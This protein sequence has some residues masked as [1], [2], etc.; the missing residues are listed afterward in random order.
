MSVGGEESTGPVPP[1]SAGGPR[2]TEE[3]ME[4]LFDVPLA[5]LRRP[6]EP[7]LLDE[8]LAAARFAPSAANLQPWTFVRVS[9]PRTVSIIAEHALSSLGLP[10]PN[11]RNEALAQAAHLVLVCLNVLRAKCRFGDRG[12]ELFAVQ[13]VAA[14]AHT[15]RL[16]AL[17]RGIASHWVREL[18]LAALDEALG[19]SPRL[20]LQAVIAFGQAPDRQL[21]RPPRLI[22]SQ[23]V[24]VEGEP[25]GAAGSPDGTGA[26]EGRS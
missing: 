16:A 12:L 11:H 15:V 18:D 8:A 1:G 23:F 6:V 20:R 3:L 9:Q 4:A 13:D 10:L 24:R 22:P 5:A 21:E 25:L 2:S 7:R 26:G 19:L 17:E 14:A